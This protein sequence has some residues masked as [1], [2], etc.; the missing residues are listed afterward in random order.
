MKN[1]ELIS[2]WLNDELSA[3]ELDAFKKTEDY[4][5]YGDI[6]E[7]AARFK[8]P[9]FSE[10]QGLDRLKE[11]MAAAH[12]RPVRKLHFSSFYKIAAVLVVFIASG[13]FLF[14]NAPKTISTGYTE[15]ASMELPD[16][17]K[18]YLNADSRV[19]YKP[20]KW[21]SQRKLDLQGEAFFEV[22]KGQKFTVETKQG[23]ISVLGT[24]F[25][26]NSRS[27]Y[28][29]VQ[30]YEGAV[31]VNLENSEWILEKGKSLKMIDGKVV[32]L[33]DIKHA[34][35]GWT[36]QES[37]FDAVPLKQVLTELERQFNIQ[38]ETRDV[39]LKQLFTGSFSHTNK[40]I[41]LQ[42]VSIPL[43]LK[44]KFETDNKVVLYE[45]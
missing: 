40:E 3:R 44:Y 14:L 28:F 17:S 30:C 6:V 36:Y 18:V 43:R 29:E 24:K 10:Q 5:A 34:L 20:S 2:K 38:I 15:M 37:E 7:K 13:L 26:V 25:N 39:D 32:G 16:E 35:P 9:E 1:K 21:A 31:K 12:D 11:K 41:A 22:K 8:R 42:S 33:Q 4:E 45:E 27:G 23:S 19:K